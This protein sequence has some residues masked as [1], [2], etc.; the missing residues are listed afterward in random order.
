MAYAGWMLLGD[1]AVIAAAGAL[2]VVVNEGCIGLR[3]PF[4]LSGRF[5]R[6]RRRAATSH[7]VLLGGVAAM[8]VGVVALMLAAVIPR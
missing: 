5:G 2:A 6:D 8:V 7:A 4:D 3:M 1:G